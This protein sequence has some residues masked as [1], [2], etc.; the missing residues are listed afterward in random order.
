MVI[1]PPLQQVLLDAARLAIRNELRGIRQ[2]SIPATTDPVLMMPAG[3]FV[4]LH[5]A[6][7]HQIGR[8]SCRERV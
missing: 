3:C 4:T 2:Y 1:P 5:D 7:S 8:A 6:A